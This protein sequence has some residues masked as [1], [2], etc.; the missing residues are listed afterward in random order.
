MSDNGLIRGDVFGPPPPIYPCKVVGVRVGGTLV[1]GD[2][3]KAPPD[4]M[5]FDIEINTT[6]GIKT[7]TNAK[8][9]WPPV[10]PGVDVNGEAVMNSIGWVWYIPTQDRILPFI[11]MPPDSIDCDKL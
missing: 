11:Y 9:H 4:Q 10:D 3:A 1:T 8:S 5:G 2:D 7:L 6:D